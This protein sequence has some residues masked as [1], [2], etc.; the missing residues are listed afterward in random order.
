MR[1]Q[2]TLDE[3]LKLEAIIAQIVLPT[4]RD[5]DNV[6]ADIGDNLAGDSVATDI[7]PSSH[8]GDTGGIWWQYGCRFVQLGH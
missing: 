5:G 7:G 3:R 1:R 8:R 6:V 4:C 2:C